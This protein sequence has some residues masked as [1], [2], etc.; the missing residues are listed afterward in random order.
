MNKFLIVVVNAFLALSLFTACGA[1]ETQ[2]FQKEIFVDEPAAPVIDS[3]LPLPSWQTPAEREDARNNPRLQLLTT[4]HP[5]T[6]TIVT[7]AEWEPMEAVVIKVE[8]YSETVEF[9]GQLINGILAG[10]ALPVLLVDSSLLGQR[11]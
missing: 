11:H 2:D 3:A 1:P 4:G 7:P 5:P 9:Y 8:T 6:G 10:G